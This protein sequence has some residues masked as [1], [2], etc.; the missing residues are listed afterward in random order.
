MTPWLQITCGRINYRP[1]CDNL[2]AHDAAGACRGSLVGE[3]DACRMPAEGA[4]VGEERAGRVPALCQAC[5]VR[6]HVNPGV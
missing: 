5:S 3:Q 6:A 2:S 4:Y 1:C